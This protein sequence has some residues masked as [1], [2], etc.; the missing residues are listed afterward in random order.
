MLKMRLRHRPNASAVTSATATT[1]DSSTS[2]SA[3]RFAPVFVV[4]SR[5][6][7]LLLS[8]SAIPAGA[9]C[10]SEAAHEYRVNEDL[11]RAIAHVESGDC[12][13]GKAVV[14][15][16]KPRFGRVSEDLGCMQINDSWLSHPAISSRGITREKLLRDACLNVKVGAWILANNFNR[17][18]PNWN[19]VGAYNA[20]CKNLAAKD[21]A[22]LRNSYS[23]RV[24]RAM[25]A[26]QR[27]AEFQRRGAEGQ[28]SRASVR[29]DEIQLAEG[30]TARDAVVSKITTVSFQ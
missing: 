4:A 10:F 27:K 16:N 7:A 30:A 28:A 29:A 22:A 19:G 24:Y 9:T 18:G 12:A 8:V 23:W 3:S 14:G 13:N 26:Q 15:V 11:L 17:L 1:T 25:N 21:C 2:K 20:G 5:T 6:A